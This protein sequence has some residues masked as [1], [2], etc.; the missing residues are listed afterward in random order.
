MN[1][2][3][4]L[5]EQLRRARE[6]RG[7]SLAE[8]A[9]ATKVSRSLFEALERGDCSRWPGGIYSRAYVRD[10]AKAIGLPPEEV[11]ARFAACFEDK[12]SAAADPGRSPGETPDAAP[13]LRL[14]IASDP[15]DRL[16]TLLL[17]ARL[18]AIDAVL[19]L[20]A[21]AA[22]TAATGA[23]FWMSAALAILGCHA[24]GVLRTGGS[25]G[26]I[27]A[28]SL[29]RAAGPARAQADDPRDEPVATGP[30]SMQLS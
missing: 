1:P 21:A 3:A 16:A 14:T 6:R 17:H 27:T 28:A 20:G 29:R 10:Y 7:I 5:A 18:L 4:A 2:R 24:A 25:A 8:I 9:A 23:G 22:V 30:T 12:P 13:T 11:L 15:A 19:A 26:W